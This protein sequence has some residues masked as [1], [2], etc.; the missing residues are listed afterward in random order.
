MYNTKNFT[1]IVSTKITCFLLIFFLAK[2]YAQP[3]NSSIKDVV[4]PS[5]TTNSLEAVYGDTSESHNTEVPDESIS[6][7]KFKEGKLDT[8][9]SLSKSHHQCN[10]YLNCQNQIPACPYLNSN[11]TG[12]SPQQLTISNNCYLN[13]DGILKRT[14]KFNNLVDLRQTDASAYCAN[15]ELMLNLDIAMLTS[16]AIHWGQ[17]D[18]NTWENI[19][20]MVCDVNRAYDCA[21]KPRPI[22]SFENYEFVDKGVH[23]YEIC[24]EVKL[25]FQDELIA[26]G[27]WN[28]YQSRTHF[29]MNNIVYED[30]RHVYDYCHPDCGA[31]DISRIEARMY[32]YY[33]ARRFINLGFSA[34]D[35]A[36]IAR[37]TENDPTGEY[38][39]S[40][41]MKFKE[42]AEETNGGTFLINGGWGKLKLEGTDNLLFDFIHSSIRPVETTQY[43]PEE[44][45]C[46]EDPL[47]AYIDPNGHGDQLFNQV[48]SGITPNGCEI[49]DCIPI[50]LRF[51][52]HEGIET[53]A[54]DGPGIADDLFYSI[55][56]YDESVW[57]KNL[58]TECKNDWFTYYYCNLDNAIN[59]RTYLQIPGRLSINTTYPPTYWHAVDNPSFFD[60]LESLLDTQMPSIRVQQKCQY[61]TICDTQIEQEGE[62]CF[63]SERKGGKTVYSL[64]I[65]NQDCSTAYGWHIKK[66]NG[67]WIPFNAVDENYTLVPDQIGVYEITLEVKNPVLTNNPNFSR[68]SIKINHLYEQCCDS[69][70]TFVSMDCNGVFCPSID[71]DCV[72]DLIININ[73]TPFQ[74]LYES[75]NNITTQGPV[76]IPANQQVEYNSNKVILNPGFIVEHGADFKARNEGCD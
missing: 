67:T 25:A 20:G 68:P 42:Y 47:Q 19:R 29:D 38:T 26:L 44:N 50:L 11:C 71:N 17:Q 75:S 56:G 15:I 30:N 74:N 70:Y 39:Y 31:P 46:S 53:D 63:Y 6:I 76:T 22:F 34:V 66:P 23:W 73:N 8:E 2:V 51:D 27:L 55:Y 13:I 60:Q 7:T 59:C 69:K 21:G 12:D 65:A 35:M 5:T 49:E 64:S 3:I 61:N 36:H 48:I 52:H 9:V 32:M 1:I 18:N 40:V 45:A 4:A 28:Q 57:W 62:C 16:T 43:F 72:D 41:I 14:M 10:I 37:Y 54:P 33:L 58:S 24:D